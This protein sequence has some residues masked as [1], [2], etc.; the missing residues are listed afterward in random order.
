[1]AILGG[2]LIGSLPLAAQKGG[3]KSEYLVFVGT[4]TR[5]GKSQGIYAYKFQSA[6]G[7]LTSIGLAAEIASPSFLTI[8]PNQKYLYAV[9]EAYGVGGEKGGAVSAFAIDAAAGKLNFLNRVSTKGGGPCHLNVDKTGKALVVVNYGTGSTASMPV[10]EDGRLGEAASFIQHAGSSADPS[11]QKGP[12]AHSVNISPD[13]RFAIVA[14]LGLDQV[15]VYKLDPAKATISSNDPP[16]TKV[17]PG[18]GPRHFSFHPN[19]KFGY[20]INEM[21]NTVTAFAWDAPKGVLK[22]IQTL[23]TLPAD[24]KGVSHTAEVLVH[25]SGKFLYGSN[26]GHD[27]IAVFSIDKSKGTLTPVDRTPTQ[28]KLPRNFRIDPTGNYL[29]AANMNSDSMVIFRIDQKTGKLTPTG[30][31]IQLGSP[32][33]IKFVP[34]P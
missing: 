14:D 29:I 27:S 3:A 20:V 26:R 12:H 11:R 7:K 10:M 5:P 2:T 15:L 32:V 22:E 33:C 9:T 4:Y 16:F 13:N 8:H 34:L 23:T 28:G 25:P 31:V 6:T 21:G 1:M 30:D 24:F 18:A 17:A 19:G